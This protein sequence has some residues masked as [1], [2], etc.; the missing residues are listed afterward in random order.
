MSDEGNDGNLG[1]TILLILIGAAVWFAWSSISGCFLAD[2]FDYVTK[3]C[4]LAHLQKPACNSDRDILGVD[5]VTDSSY[6]ETS[7]KRDK[8]RTV[9]YS[10][11]KR[12]VDGP[13]SAAVMRDSATLFKTEKGEW[14]A[15]CEN[16]PT[17]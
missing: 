15:S 6:T 11:R 5:E 10:F 2:Q 12:P 7:G 4:A 13:V 14:L 16:V 1:C 17:H 8:V 9:I 3:A